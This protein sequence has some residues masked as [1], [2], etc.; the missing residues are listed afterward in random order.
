MLTYVTGRSPRLLRLGRRSCAC[1]VFP[2]KI[3]FNGGLFARIFPRKLEG[4]SCGRLSWPL[5]G[6]YCGRVSILALL[7]LLCS[8]PIF[9]FWSS[10]LGPSIRNQ[11]SNFFRLTS[12]YGALISLIER[13]LESHRQMH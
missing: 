13:A 1:K 8:Y 2:C 6:T 12:L 7:F 5:Y 4:F 9:D 11:I 10:L 3:R